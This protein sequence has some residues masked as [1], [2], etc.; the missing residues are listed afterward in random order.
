MLIFIFVFPVA[1]TLIS[2]N[3]L[4]F[5]STADS[6]TSGG[7]SS[8]ASIEDESLPQKVLFRPIKSA[9]LTPPKQQTEG[10]I[11]SY[12]T[13]YFRLIFKELYF[14]FFLGGI[15]KPQVV[16]NTSRNLDFL[17]EVEEPIAGMYYP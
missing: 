11:P 12:R 4:Y 7:R 13:I 14:L 17:P 5:I 3:F 10:S 8:S 1:S 9:P 6:L 16:P 2:I 15:L